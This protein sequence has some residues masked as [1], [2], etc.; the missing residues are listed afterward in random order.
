MRGGGMESEA[1]TST[2]STFRVVDDREVN[3]E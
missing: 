3:D 1:G 2:S